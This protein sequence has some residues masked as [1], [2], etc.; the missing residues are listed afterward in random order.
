MFTFVDWIVSAAEDERA[1]ALD[2]VGGGAAALVL[3][4]AEAILVLDQ[5][6][7]IRLRERAGAPSS[8]PRRRVSSSASNRRASS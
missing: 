6:S 1:Q 3:S 2:V 7:Q 4:R 8:S 5:L